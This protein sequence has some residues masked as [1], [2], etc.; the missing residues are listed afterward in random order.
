MPVSRARARL[1]QAAHQRLE[2]LAIF[3]LFRILAR[4]L[5]IL[6]SVANTPR[7]NAAAAD[8]VVVLPSN[9]EKRSI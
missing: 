6:L 2:L 9:I 1:F 4:P 5:L 8:L 3:G 7:K